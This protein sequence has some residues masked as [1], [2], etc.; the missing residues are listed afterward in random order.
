[1]FHN[2]LA[3]FVSANSSNFFCERSCTTIE[4][5]PHGFVAFDELLAEVKLCLGEKTHRISGVTIV[6][7]R[8]YFDKKPYAA[9]N[10]P[11]MP[12]LLLAN[13]PSAKHVKQPLQSTEQCR[14]IHNR[15]ARRALSRGKIPS[16]NISTT[17]AKL[18]NAG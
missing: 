7:H 15:F 11:R 18:P 10:H 14:Y 4:T 17:D 13:S 16:Q 2:E 8:G 5:T 9:L 6:Y 12:A 1:M 3:N